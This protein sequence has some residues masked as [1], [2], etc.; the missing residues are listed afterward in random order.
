MIIRLHIGYKTRYGQEM[1]VI[2]K[3]KSRKKN[4]ELR[5]IKMQY[6]QESW[7]TEIDTEELD[8]K[9]TLQYRYVLR[10]S[11]GPDHFDACAEREINPKKIKQENISV[12]DEWHANEFHAAVFKSKP[13]SEVIFKH[14]TGKPGK[15]EKK[16]THCFRVEAPYLQNGRTVCIMGSSKAM[17]EWSEAHAFEMNFAD[18]AWTASLNLHK[19][20]FPITY[21]YVVR[22]DE[23]NRIVQYEKGPD[24]VIYH[25]DRK[26]ELFMYSAFPFFD[27]AVWRGTGINFPVSALRS[28]ASWGVGDFTDLIPMVDWAH[29]NGI[30]MMQLLPINDT[31]ATHTIR[32]SYPYASVSA[33]ALHPQYLNVAKL[34]K[35]CNYEIEEEILDEAK[36]LNASKTLDHVA[37]AKLKLNVLKSL[38]NKEKD[39][40]HDDLSYFEFFNMNRDW[41]VPYAAYCYLRDLNN[42]ADPSTWADY[43]DY[44]EAQIQE[45]VSPDTSHYD[46]IAIYYFIQ[47]HLHLQFLDAV[48]YG[49]SRGIIFKGDL[50]IGVGR[51][52]VETW[53]N[54]KLFHMDMQAGAPPDAFAI[55]GQNWDFPTYNW[56]EMARDNYAWWRNRMGNMGTYFDAIRID[57]ILGF[58]RIWSIPRTAVE[59]ILGVFVPALPFS[60]QELAHAGLSIPAARLAEPYV[61]DYLVEQIFG[62]DANWVR[63]HVIDQG[64]LCAA[65]R[66]Q[67]TTDAYF[68]K[69]PEKNYLRQAIFDL[70]ADVVLI[71]DAEVDGYYHFRINM[72]STRSYQSLETSQQNVM[73][74]LYQQYFFGKQDELWKSVGQQKLNALQDNTPMLLCAEDLG[75]VPDFVED[76]LAQREI[77]SLG[78]QRMPK[79]ITER[80]S[81]PGEASYMSVVTP[82]TH[83]TSTIRQWW[84][85]DKDGI[86]YFYNHILGQ[87]G[88]APY[89]CEPWVAA[90]VIRQHLHAPSMWAVFLMQDLLAMSASLRIENP[91]EE[92]I[93]IPADPNHNWN[94]RM[95]LPVEDLLDADDFNNTLRHMIKNSGR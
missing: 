38:Y 8:M 25:E 53:V 93:N 65:F 29:K 92:R 37:V 87:Y 6:D 43:Q 61:N 70:I 21:K 59:G 30:R 45:L 35:D 3:G 52:S 80:F 57:H 91:D 33:F 76:V 64:K 44:D 36:K 90:E 83:D 62:E 74:H 28:A 2:L 49:H 1:Y 23:T 5:Q 85:E 63:E 9:G 89:Y 39:D 58:F 32:D 86:Q 42:S 47:Y 88:M 81:Q 15:K 72:Q 40:F 16:S 26:D 10:D 79:K 7:W 75:M 22:E 78:V 54:P 17:G 11:S 13:F 27:Q 84:E 68:K 48:N 51:H 56:E 71:R 82:S 77:L 19:E 69:N 67:E 20:H 18:G 41:L 24:R 34:A 95:H 50:P 55:K 4:P 66:N 60:E 73:N 94:Y 12:F 14:R 31:I 46:E